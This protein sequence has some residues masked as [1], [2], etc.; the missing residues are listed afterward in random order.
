MVV[1][2]RALWQAPGD[3]FFTRPIFIPL[4]LTAL[5]QNCRADKI[6]YLKMLPRASLKKFKQVVGT[7][8]DAHAQ[9]GVLITLIG[10]HHFLDDA[11]HDLFI[12]SINLLDFMLTDIEIRAERA[13]RTTSDFSISS[14]MW[15]KAAAI[16][17]ERI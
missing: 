14:D 1:T 12:E 7:A 8:A 17:E 2:I 16:S 9:I 10:A 13:V 11:Q 5:P 15:T 3:F 4:I 6:D